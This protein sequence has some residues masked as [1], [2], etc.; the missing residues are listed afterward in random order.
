MKFKFIIILILIA[1]CFLGMSC[2]KRTVF[3]E[4]HSTPIQ[5]KLNLPYKISKSSSKQLTLL[6]I[7]KE[8]SQCMIKIEG[9]SEKNN[10]RWY[11]VGEFIFPSE[12]GAEGVKLIGI[13]ENDVFI[14][15]HWGDSRTEYTWGK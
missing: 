2:R 10:V 8:K 14:E 1:V 3:S 4:Y 12:L 5:L 7:D 13:G 15:R 9:S 6:E 11:R